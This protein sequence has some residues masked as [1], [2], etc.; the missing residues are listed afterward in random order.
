MAT[1]KDIAKATGFSIITV[2]RVVNEPHKVKPATR[3]IIEAEI[4]RVNYKPNVLARALVQRKT[5]IIYVY[6][7]AAYAPNN[8]FFMNVIAGIGEFLGEQGYSLLL[9]RTWYNKEDCDGC[10]FMGLNVEEEKKVAELAQELPVCVFGYAP[11][12]TSI[13]IDNFD[14]IYQMTRYV[15]EKGYD[16]LV[17]VSIAQEDRFVKDREHGFQR[18]I[19]DVQPA[20]RH[21]MLKVHN[22]EN[23]AFQGVMQL[24]N[25]G[26]NPRVLICASD[27]IAIGAMRALKNHGLRVPE[28]VKI[29]GFDGLGMDEVAYPQLTTVRQPIYTAGRELAIH[30]IDLINRKNKGPYQH[31]QIKPK[32]IKRDTL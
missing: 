16:Q 19:R 24:L 6:I 17:Y 27:D 11:D 28:D 1:L 18:A 29:T 20:V 31:I 14:G 3:A 25:D 4:K 22:N 10:I 26:K 30:I 23:A 21:L 5:N 15:L 32:V 12:V 8:L 2:S 9:K 7:P 13:D